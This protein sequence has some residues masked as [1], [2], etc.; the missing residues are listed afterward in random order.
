M[1]RF[2][3]AYMLQ[4]CASELRSVYCMMSYLLNCCNLTAAGPYYME[5]TQTVVQFGNVELYA[6]L[7]R[8]ALLQCV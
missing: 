4:Q 8:I 3:F 6:V 7:H 5:V 2:S 1:H